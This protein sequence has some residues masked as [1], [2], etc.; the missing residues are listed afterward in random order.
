MTEV[1]PTHLH[2]FATFAIGG[3]QVRA[4][5]LM[6]M[7]AGS[8]RHKII[9]MDGRTDCLDKVPEGVEVEVLQPP[10]G[11]LLSRLRQMR[12]T[13]RELKPDLLLTYNWGAIE[14]LLS[15][16]FF[17]G[18]PIVHH[19]D[20]F[21]PEETERF[22][23]R[24]IYARRFAFGA[25]RTVIVPS[26]TLL[27]VA[28][29][30]WR[31]P[32]ERLVYL[33]N[34]V[35]CERFTPKPASTDDFVIGLVGGVRPE[36]NQALAVE[37]LALMKQPA[38]LRIVGDGPDLK[39]LRAL[40]VERK[41]SDRI[42]FVGAVVDTAPCYQDFNAFL[43]SSRTEQMPIAMLEAMAS[44]LPVVGTDVGDVEDMLTPSNRRFVVPRGDAQALAQALDELASD[45]SLC[46]D[47]GEANRE[48]CVAEFTESTCYGAYQAQYH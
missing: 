5:K 37:A 36:K 3:P 17:G 20:G 24:R 34:G 44:G 41:L 16:R 33:P 25:V 8:V 21:G 7:T 12:Q 4:A 19:E 6:G 14:W 27:A 31:I 2:V 47:L 40:A 45:A 13:I 9:A 29:A 43:I 46:A 42:D 28:E 38:R 26:R 39:S 23:R 1:R 48:R 18:C 35:D 32:P 10:R 11:G 22:L 30:H 15:V